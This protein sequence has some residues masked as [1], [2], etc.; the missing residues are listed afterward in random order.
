MNEPETL[1]NS[2]DLSEELTEDHIDLISK[3][4]SE[5][6]IFL[7]A[8]KK[9]VDLRTALDLG[10]SLATAQVLSYFFEKYP[11]DKE[12]FNLAWDYTKGH[13]FEAGK[14]KREWQESVGIYN[15]SLTPKNFSFF[16]RRHSFLVSKFSS[17]IHSVH[18]SD[19][20]QGGV[21]R[22]IRNYLNKNSK[23]NSSA[24]EIKAFLIPCLLKNK[25]TFT[26]KDLNGSFCFDSPEFFDVL[27]TFVEHGTNDLYLYLVDSFV[28]M[29]INRVEQLRALNEAYLK[30]IIVSSYVYFN[31][32]DLVK[33]L[34]SLDDSED[35]TEILTGDFN[36]VL[37]KSSYRVRQI[38]M[39]YYA[40][41]H[42]I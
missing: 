26:S 2:E 42:R 39:D 28:L 21:L 41:H 34:L 18:L 15:G 30:K 40:Q 17:Y 4:R 29:Y 12:D 33:G 11:K 22:E 38:D 23:K 13:L 16:R 32:R 25:I 24:D 35:H 20:S 7:E 6:F 31:L 27:S 3:F 10:P 36:R 9:I 1:F 19:F 5:A 14:I 8:D 37:P